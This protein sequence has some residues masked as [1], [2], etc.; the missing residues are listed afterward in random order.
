MLNDDMLIAH[1]PA[2]TGFQAALPPRCRLPS[3]RPP[4]PARV[5]R[6]L[7]ILCV[8]PRPQRNKLF[9]GRATDAILLASATKVTVSK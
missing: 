8:S 4:V 3:C 6:C 5:P 2:C 9:L 7:A 1:R